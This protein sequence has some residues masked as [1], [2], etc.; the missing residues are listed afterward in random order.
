MED[1]N[2]LINEACDW[3][4]ERLENAFDEELKD[5]ITVQACM[6][7]LMAGGKRIR[8]L[9]CYLSSD[10]LGVS[11]DEV[12]PFAAALEMI[13]TYS[14]IHDDLPAMDNDDLRRGKPTCHKRFGEGIAVLAGDCLLN[15]A[16]E[17][18][19]CGV[20][21]NPSD[22]RAAKELASLSGINGMVGGQSI[23]LASEN[24]SISIDRLYELQRKKTGALLKAAVMLPYYMFET[25][26]SD[27]L[28]LELSEISNCLGLSFQIKDDILDLESDV[29]T[30]GKSTGKDERDHKST[31]VTLLGIEGAREELK[32]NIELCYTHLDNIRDMGYDVSRFEPVIAF[33]AG[34]DH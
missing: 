5:D 13:H 12:L 33:F 16:F 19:T 30:L 3:V 7:S 29:K 21:R 11:K 17:T 34:R 24:K 22:A 26:F 14:L 6:Y 32:H 8:P 4:E 9:L 15:R 27:E 28:A 25:R 31:F 20:A 23:D 10:M 2:S 1:I 18:V